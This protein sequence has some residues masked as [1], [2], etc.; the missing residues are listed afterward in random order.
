MKKKV[1]VLCP[2]PDD[3]IFSF[4]QINKLSTE[5]NLIS[6]LFFTENEIRRKE[7]ELSCQLKNW[8]ILFACDFGF[9]FSDG[10]LHLNYKK[11]DF[12]INKIIN[13]FEIIFSPAIEGGHQDHDTIGL[14]I[15][16]Q[17]LERKD[18]QFYFYTTYTALGTFGLYLVMSKSNYAEDLF[19]ED[20]NFV[21]KIDYKS[22]LFF[23]KVYKSQLI[24]GLLLFVPWIV[25]IILNK[26]N[27][28]YILKNK[29]YINKNKLIYSLKGIPLYEI[30]GRCTKKE[31]IAEIN[32]YYLLK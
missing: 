26:S 28:T 7:A 17:A 6:A 30:H 18:K 12:F 11:L 24:S 27:C 29:F 1:L 2:H 19:V 32:S 31:W 3:E 21:S 13:E 10:K 4:N 14:N 5:N 23:F 8:D 22:I 16:F 20:I 15:F 25:Q 9:K